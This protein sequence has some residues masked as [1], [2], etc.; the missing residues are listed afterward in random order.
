MQELIITSPQH[1]KVLLEELLSDIMRK[2]EI[3]EQKS[4]AQKAYLN[5]EQA[6]NYL[7]IAHSTLYSYNSKKVIPYSNR[8]KKLY[9]LKTDL[10]AFVAQHRKGTAAEQVGQMRAKLKK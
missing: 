9:Y 2:A 4:E 10:D 7:S 6:A 1:L 8:G 5:F 3:G